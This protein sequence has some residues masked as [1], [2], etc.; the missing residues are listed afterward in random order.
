MI[1]F[2]WDKKKIHDFGKACSQQCE[3]CNRDVDWHLVYIRLYITLFSIQLF[4]YYK[5]YM[6][7]C[8]KCGGSEV[9]DQNEARS[10]L[11]NL[12]A[13]GETEGDSK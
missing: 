9:I 10:L 13:G 5:K 8:P 7:V 4:P 12:E 1:L 3:S 2:G 6:L 11:E